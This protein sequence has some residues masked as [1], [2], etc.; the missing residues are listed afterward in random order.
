MMIEIGDTIISMDLFETLFCCDLSVC[1][2]ICCV[3]GDSGAPLE[4]DEVGKLEE[5]LPV[6][7]EDLSEASRNVINR[8]GVSYVDIEGDR[9]T[10]IVNGGE[11][12]FS[13]TD[14]NGVC[15]CAIEKAF[16]EGR[17]D[18]YKPI[19][20]HLYPVRLRKLSNGTVA[21]NIH[22]WDVCKCAF[23]LGKKQGL[24]VYKFLETPLIRRFGK[25]WYEQVCI[26]A[27]E[28]V[29]LGIK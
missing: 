8:Q 20:C 22:K 9:V 1:K 3:E 14:A 13:H 18:F 27:Q 29:K 7:W 12:V 23:S 28:I 21:V 6:V 26:A 2:G 19:S 16:L 15:K 11:C 24:P 5:L 4:D 10:S 25:E 17:T